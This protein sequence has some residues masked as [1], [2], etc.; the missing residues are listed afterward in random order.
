V[1]SEIEGHEADVATVTDGR[2]AAAGGV[3]HAEELIEFA[4]AVVA[5]D[6]ARSERA[7]TRLLETVGPDAFVDAAGVV[8]NF[9]RM[10]RIA[11]GT[12]IPL[13]APLAVVSQE[14]R[15]D[16]GINAFGSAENT[17]TPGPLGVLAGRVLAP[18]A[19]PLFRLLG[20]SM[21]G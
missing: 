19:S 7:R 1:S 5:E 17:P 9:M 16:L 3:P 12:G 20:R 13:D 6:E 8:G 4:E 11:D 2:S 14:I 10:V 18:F 15:N 21:R